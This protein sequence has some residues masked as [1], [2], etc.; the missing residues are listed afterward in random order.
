[1]DGLP[2]AVIRA[3]AT[4]VGDLSVDIGVGRR[5]ALLQQRECAHDHAGLAVAALW[6][7]ELRPGDLQRMASV[8]REPL[9]REH[10]FTDSSRGGNAA[11]ANGASVDMQRARAALPDAAA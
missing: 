8:G 2:D 5:W 6:R 3:T 1:M 9:D 4:G 7:V 11:G 10:R